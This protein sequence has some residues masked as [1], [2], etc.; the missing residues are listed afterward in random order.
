[1]KSIFLK[2]FINE[3]TLIVPNQRRRQNETTKATAK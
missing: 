3:T 2:V 1:M